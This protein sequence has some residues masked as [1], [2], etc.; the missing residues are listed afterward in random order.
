MGHMGESGDEKTRCTY[1]LCVA[2][3]NTPRE[4]RSNDRGITNGKRARVVKMLDLST[5]TT[6]ECVYPSCEGV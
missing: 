4:T 3:A 2:S 6:E 1:I 5:L